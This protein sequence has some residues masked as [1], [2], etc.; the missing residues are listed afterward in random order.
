MTYAEF[1]AAY[2]EFAPADETLVG[3]KL[4]D[5]DLRTSTSYAAEVRDIRV[6][7]LA[8]RLLA[9]SPYGR[10][11]RLVNKDGST[12]YDADLA[13]M[14]RANMAGDTY[15]IIDRD[16]K[17]KKL[18]AKLQAANVA[19]RIGVREGSRKD[20]RAAE[21]VATWNE[22]GTPWSPARSFIGAWFDATY[23]ENQALVH[24]MLQAV[25]A[26]QLTL[27]RMIKMLRV[28][29]V[30]QV[31]KRIA[32]GIDP[33]NAPSTIARKGSSKPL[34]ASGQL[35]TSIAAWLEGS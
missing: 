24:R 19:I 9:L 1:V 6:G 33:P 27:E 10:D 13:A 16:A 29:F 20:G 26:G 18:V 8:A 4:V 7:L 17:Y 28:L 23:V 32:D 5:A 22:F 34:I 31:Q 12:V 15:V 21:D 14:D 35:R 3:L 30:G 2:P 25:A 11:M